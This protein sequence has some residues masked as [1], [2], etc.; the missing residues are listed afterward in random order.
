M[1]E[2]VPIG[3][4]G[5]PHRRPGFIRLKSFAEFEDY[6]PEEVIFLS[7]NG[8]YVPYFVAETA[9][10]GAGLLLRLEDIVSRAAAF[11]L[12]G[13]SVFVRLQDLPPDMRAP[14]TPDAGRYIG[15]TVQDKRLGLIGTVE[16]IADN[17]AHELLVVSRGGGTVLIPWV[18]AFRIETDAERRVLY[19]DL[20]QFLVDD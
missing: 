17:G 4:F 11:E 15:F 18:E 6:V 14:R 16:D 20:P 8:D 1:A 13:R 10:D 7:E 9:R 19:M 3:K 2:F 5:S 12:T